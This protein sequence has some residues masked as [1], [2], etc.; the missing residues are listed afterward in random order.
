MGFYSTV[1][2][3][4][5]LTVNISRDDLLSQFKKN[6]N[7]LKFSLMNI[8]DNDEQ[9]VNSLMNKIESELT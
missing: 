5:F 7:E 6:R 9:L 1:N 2:E 8:L 3:N 4:E